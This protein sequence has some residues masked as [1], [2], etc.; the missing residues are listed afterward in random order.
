MRKFWL[1]ILIGFGLIMGV[2]W[3]SEEGYFSDLSLSVGGEPPT[4]AE[5]KNRSEALTSRGVVAALR[6]MLCPAAQ[7]TITEWLQTME[8]EY[9]EFIGFDDLSPGT[10]V[11]DGLEDTTKAAEL[12]NDYE[13]MISRIERD[14]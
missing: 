13:R 8:S 2:V 6:A 5:V 10:A 3:I 9:P 11:F 14:C 7:E 4:V 12:L 1:V